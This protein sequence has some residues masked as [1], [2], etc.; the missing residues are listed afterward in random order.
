MD[1]FIFVLAH[2]IP[3]EEMI[4]TEF[5]LFYV[6]FA[7]ERYTHGVETGKHPATPGATLVAHGFGLS[8]LEEERNQIRK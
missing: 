7:H 4:L 5:K 6:E 8:H 2:L 1:Q 3:K